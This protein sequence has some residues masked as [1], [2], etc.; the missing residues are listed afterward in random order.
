MNRCKN[1]LP[2]RTALG[3]NPGKASLNIY[4][5]HGNNSIFAKATETLE[6]QEEVSVLTQDVLAEELS[7]SLLSLI[8]VDTEGYELK[9]VQGRKQTINGLKP[10]IVG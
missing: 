9:V 5:K 7:L 6:R 8:K 1:I 2:I 3:D 4:K 10:K